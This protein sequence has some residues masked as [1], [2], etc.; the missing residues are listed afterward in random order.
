MVNGENV[1][2][3]PFAVHV[4]ARQFKAGLSFKQHGSFFGAFDYPWGMTVNEHNEIAVTDREYSRVQVFSSDGTCLRSFG[5]EGDQE[6]EFNDPVGI[7]F[8]D[9]EDIIVADRMNSRVQ[10][11][12]GQGE[13]LGQFG[14]EGNL[15]HQLNDPWGLSLESDG[16]IVSDSE[17]QAIKIFS[18]SDQFIR[19][20]GRD[21]TLNDPIHCI[22]KDEYFV[23]SDAGGHCI[24]VFNMEHKFL[25]KFGK[26]GVEMESSISRK[27]WRLTIWGT[28]WSVI[29]K[30]TEC[31][32]SICL[33]SL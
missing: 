21:D 2:G 1:R 13:Y 5:S 22:Q 20:F 25:Y 27:V 28:C 4:K 32:C 33:G 29:L 9:N 10:I 30:I 23:V 26:E 12:S 14:G 18:P 17:S 31:R 24:K 15:D 7:A 8:H 3:S 16:N 19:K 11:F 6:G